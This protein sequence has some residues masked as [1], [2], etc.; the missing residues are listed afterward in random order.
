VV[1]VADTNESYNDAQ[2]FLRPQGTIVAVGI[3][4]DGAIVAPLGLAVI[5][6]H[7][8]VG[9]YLG[10]R[11]DAVEAMDLVAHG[12]VSSSYSVEPLRNLP[13]V[14]ERMG[15]GKT[16]GRVVLDCE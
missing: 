3:P 11:Q 1:V 7:R 8:I 14:F 10:N 2:Q 15:A 9:S 5:F 6:E 13:D 4:K 16:R 12:D